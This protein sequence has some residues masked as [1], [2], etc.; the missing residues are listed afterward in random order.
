MDTLHAPPA[1]EFIDA[2]DGYRIPVRVFGRA[3][4]GRPVILVHG[5]QSHSGWFVQSARWLAGL[6]LPVYAFDRR[7]SGSSRV[8]SH[9]GPR[10]VGLLEEM[11]VVADF[12]LEGR[13]ATTLHV[14]GHCFGAVP[15]L[16]YA[17]FYRPQRVTTLVLATPGLYTRT[18]VKLRHKVAIV[19]GLVTRRASEIPVPLSPEQFSEIDEYVE[20]VRSDPLALRTIAGQFLFEL[21]RARRRLH[22]AARKLRAP[23]L[24]ALAGDDPIC[25]NRRNRAFLESVRASKEIHEYPG[26]RHI[27]EFSMQRDAFFADLEDWFGRHAGPN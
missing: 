3:G 16:L 20:F 17:A 5:L 10:L 6:G 13:D 22:W 26:A 12:A 11:D 21:Q 8:A 18:D 1:P 14:V 15:A 23:L 7:G 25:D 24:V 2:P 9:A 4:A 19:R 27:L